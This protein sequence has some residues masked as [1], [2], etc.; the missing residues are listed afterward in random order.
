LHAPYHP[1]PVM[2][3]DLS[4]VRGEIAVGRPEWQGLHAAIGPSAA[5]A[6]RVPGCRVGLARLS[7]GIGDGVLPKQAF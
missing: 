6:C 1:G 5:L 4:A 2:G 7:G 3:A